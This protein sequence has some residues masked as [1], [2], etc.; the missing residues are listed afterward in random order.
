MISNV[1][2]NF[3]TNKT[4]IAVHKV[5][6]AICRT[7]LVFVACVIAMCRQICSEKIFYHAWNTFEVIFK[8]VYLNERTI[9]LYSITI[10]IITTVTLG[11]VVLSV[12]CLKIT[13][14]QFSQGAIEAISIAL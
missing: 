12:L 8:E 5:M 4:K 6:F 2:P 9:T 3:Y 13:E 10:A 1:I 7:E 11:V 14:T